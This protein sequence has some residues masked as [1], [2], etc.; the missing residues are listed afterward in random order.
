MKKSIAIAGVVSLLS[1]FSTPHLA[2]AVV[3]TLNGQTGSTQTFT[4]DSNVTISSASNAHALG[5]SGLLPLSRGGTGAS[6]FSSGS[7]LFSNGSVISQN[8]TNLFWD[9]SNIRLGIGTSTPTSTLTVIGST[10]ISGNLNVA[11]NITNSSLVPYT[12][13]TQAV[14]LGLHDL[15]VNGLTVGKGGGSDL[16]STALGASALNSNA[17]GSKNT[18]IGFG[19]I[20]DS[21][22][23]GSNNTG[24]GYYSLHGLGG[25]SNDNTGFGYYSLVSLSAGSGNT[26]IGDYTLINLPGGANNIALGFNSGNNLTSAANNSI[27]IGA[28]TDSAGSNTA[29]VGDSSVTDVYF[30]SSAGLANIHSANTPTISSGASA[31][32]STPTAL[33]QLYIN[34]STAKV[35]ISTGTSSSADWTIMN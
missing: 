4:N 23:T 1:I 22:L 2:L 26:G 15:K 12:G 31:P 11:G 9:N 5:W 17:G 35:Y 7:L 25:N 24:V 20:S 19:A 8:N 3:Q 28:N 13:A 18:G 30:G 10:F 34:T 14:D 32:S 21:V 29:V 6:A 33:G 27:T 16:Y